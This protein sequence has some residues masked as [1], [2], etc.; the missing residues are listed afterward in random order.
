MIDKL[1][2]LRQMS[3]W[4]EINSA[5]T[6]NREVLA[7]LPVVRKRILRIPSVYLLQHI[8]ESLHLNSLCE[9][10]TNAPLNQFGYRTI[11]INLNHS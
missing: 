4:G 5:K 10:S 3:F 8:D 7:Y 6:K 9:R 11:N 2:R 1:K